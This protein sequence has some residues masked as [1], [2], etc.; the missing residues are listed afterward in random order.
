[1]VYKSADII[2][3]G[4]IARYPKRIIPL[5]RST[6]IVVRIGREMVDVPIDNRQIKFIEKEHPVGSIVELEYDSGWRIRSHTMPLETDITVMA[7]D[8]Y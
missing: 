3:F 5:S 8:I 4:E 1:M 2:T 6:H 7:Q